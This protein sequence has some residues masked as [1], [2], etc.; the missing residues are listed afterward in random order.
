M[1]VILLERVGRLGRM[2]DT[3]KVKDGFARNFLLPNHKAL[4]ATEANKAKFE[5]DRAVLEVKNNDSRAIAEREAESLQGKSFVVIRQAGESGQLYGSVSTRDISEAA[6][7]AGAHVDKN[8]VHL[9]APIKAIGMHEVELT[10]HPEVVVKLKVNVARS[11][12]EADA[13]ARGEVMT[14]NAAERAEVRAAAEALFEEAQAD[15]AAEEAAEDAAPVSKTR[16]KAKAKKPDI[17]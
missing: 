5:R 10:L 7:A 11:A 8:H 4:R 1:D 6:L 2:G 17:E 12:A 16:A 9:R 15:Q 13:Q 3:V 14:G